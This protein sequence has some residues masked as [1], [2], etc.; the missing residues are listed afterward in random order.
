MS[1]SSAACIAFVIG[2]LG[3]PASE[4]QARTGCAAID[5]PNVRKPCELQEVVSALWEQVPGK[6]SLCLS[7]LAHRDRKG[8]LVNSPDDGARCS[9]QVRE[10]FEHERQQL[11]DELYGCRSFRADLS[12][13]L[14]CEGSVLERFRP[15]PSIPLT[16][17]PNVFIQP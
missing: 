9:V 13:E 10:A 11:T 5:N 17:L 4:A 7:A 8:R 14:A 2:V 16:A 1:P 3:S 15:L 6:Y 12:R